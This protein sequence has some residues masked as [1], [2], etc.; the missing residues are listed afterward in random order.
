M[1]KNIKKNPKRKRNGNGIKNIAAPATIP[2]NMALRI[3]VVF[4]NYVFE[5]NAL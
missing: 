2:N 3:F 5:L 4:I 1:I